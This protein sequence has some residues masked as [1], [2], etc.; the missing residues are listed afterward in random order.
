MK[1]A[2][3]AY[4]FINFNLLQYNI[5]YNIQNKM[6]VVKKCVNKENLIEITKN[7]YLANNDIKATKFL[8]RLRIKSLPKL[9]LVIVHF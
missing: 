4:R 8:K 7:K 2:K 9:N 5:T 6:E 3:N 1:T